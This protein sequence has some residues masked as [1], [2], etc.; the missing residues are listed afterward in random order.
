MLGKQDLQNEVNILTK[1]NNHYAML[2]NKSVSNGGNASELNSEEDQ[3]T[4][5]TVYKNLDVKF[6]EIIQKL[7]ELYMKY[8]ILER[9]KN[10]RFNSNCH[11]EITRRG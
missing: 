8:S 11:E 10:I 1:L 6:N 5:D 7:D 4:I 9:S 2:F 3:V